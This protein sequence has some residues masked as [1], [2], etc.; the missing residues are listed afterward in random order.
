MS[1]ALLFLALLQTQLDPALDEVGSA[2]ELVRDKGLVA[3]SE[4]RIASAAARA[5]G[6]GDPATVRSKADLMAALA[7]ASGREGSDPRILAGLAIDAMVAETGYPGG[8]IDID[9][10]LR[11]AEQPQGD[12]NRSPGLA[13]R[14]EGEVAIVT[15][16]RFERDSRKRINALAK[17]PQVATARAVVLDLRGNTGGLLST[18]VEVADLF[19]DQ[20]EI[21]RLCG[22]QAGD[23]ERHLARKGDV[24]RGRPIAVLIDGKVGGGAEIL[25]AA[26]RDHGR[27]RIVGE[28]SFGNGAIRTLLQLSRRS[29]L[30][31]TTAQSF[32]PSGAPIQGT[33]VTPDVVVPATADGGDSALAA[34]ITL[35][36]GGE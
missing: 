36:G 32:R 35:L 13:V 18:A 21:M 19:L 15:F 6:S 26:L 27:A 9:A 5:I 25:A 20:G 3:V 8:H 2:L 17:E 7:A 24:A 30:S 29:A 28:T 12:E 14:R 11:A 31:L 34:A 16:A 22:R 4:D 10:V 1:I 23:G 33:G